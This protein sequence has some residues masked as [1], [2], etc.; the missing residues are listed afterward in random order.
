MKIGGKKISLS[1]ENFLLRGSSLKNTDY[2][3]GIVTFP[4]H[5]TRIMRNSTCARSKFTRVEK[6]TNLQI[7]YVFFVQMACCLVATIYGTIWR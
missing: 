2:I 5:D 7:F 1:Y 6:Q 4:G 3:Y